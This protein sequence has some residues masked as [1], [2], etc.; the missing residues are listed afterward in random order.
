MLDLNPIHLFGLP[1][2]KELKD[3]GTRF[4]RYRPRPSRDGAELFHHRLRSAEAHMKQA[5]PVFHAIDPGLGNVVCLREIYVL[6]YRFART[7]R[8][9]VVLRRGGALINPAHIDSQ[10]AVHLYMEHIALH[11]FER[12]VPF[13]YSDLLCPNC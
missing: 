13:Q 11:A 5:G 12:C 3:S 10:I 6:T 8:N 9:I 2:F 1:V 7:D 4:H